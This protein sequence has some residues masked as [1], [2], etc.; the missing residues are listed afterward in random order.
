MWELDFLKELQAA[1][2]DYIK[3]LDGEIQEE[4][5]EEKKP[6]KLSAAIFCSGERDALNVAGM[7]YFPLWLYCK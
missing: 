1:Y 4:P 6:R 2:S 3:K 5:N 7:G